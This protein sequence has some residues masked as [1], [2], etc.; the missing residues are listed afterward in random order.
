MKTKYYGL[1]RG[2]TVYLTESVVSEGKTLPENLPFVIKSFPPK[3][4]KGDK[5]D[6]NKKGYLRDYFVYGISD[7][8][9]LEFASWPVRVN[10]CQI[11]TS[12]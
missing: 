2:Q 12:L 5:N 8:T 7:S 10:V 1:E 6:R 11:K 3:V 4:R 9:N